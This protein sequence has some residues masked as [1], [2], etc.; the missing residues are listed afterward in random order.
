MTSIEGSVALVTGG[1]RGIGKAVVQALYERGASKVYA[2]A[3]DPRT[4]THPDAV[5]LA[6]EITDLGS[7]D[8]AASAAAAF[9]GEMPTEYTK[10][11]VVY[12]RYS[13]SAREPQM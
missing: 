7:V 11:G 9:G 1:S 8:A 10:P 4:V 6:L 2:T 13:M 5:P 12:F 3:R